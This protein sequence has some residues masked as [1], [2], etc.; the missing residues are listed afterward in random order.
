LAIDLTISVINATVQIDQPQADGRRIV[1]AGFLVSDPAPD[2]SPRTVLITAGHVLD[3]MPGPDVTIGYRFQ[4]Q[5]GGWSFS[6]RTLS[7][8]QGA[9]RLWIKSPEQDIAAIAIDAPPQFARAAIP[10][11]WLADEEALKQAELGPGDE[12]YVLGFPEGFSANT[13]GFPIVR[14]GRVASYPITPTR[15]F[16]N[17]LLDFHVYRGNSG[18]PVFFTPDLRR[19]SGKSPT[20][21]PVVAGIM[22]TQTVVGEESLDLGIVIQAPYIRETLKLLDRPAAAVAASASSQPASASAQPVSAST[23]R[24]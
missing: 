2:G 22:T 17:F 12:M 18:G 19:L 5:D 23:P 8:R 10:L 11:A 14:V 21:T 3:N 9:S 24:R 1:G 15:E 20:S 6:P 13:K 4:A 7:I 16:Q